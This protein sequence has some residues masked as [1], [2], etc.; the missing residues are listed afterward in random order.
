MSFG[1][2]LSATAN[3]AIKAALTDSI[4]A[5]VDQFKKDCEEKAA[6]G[7]FEGEKTYMF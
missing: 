1:D 4:R 2:G 6:G 3:V 7:Y 5:I